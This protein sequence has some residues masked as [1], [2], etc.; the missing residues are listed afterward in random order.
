M[1]LISLNKNHVNQLYKIIEAVAD[2]GCKFIIFIDDLSFEDT[3]I[4]YKHFKSIIDGGLEAQ[5][6][7]VLIYVTSNRET[8]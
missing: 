4:G 8:L 2:R 1:N 6:S 3:E 7:N 5:P